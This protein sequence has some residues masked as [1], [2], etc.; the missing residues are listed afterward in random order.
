LEHQALGE[1]HRQALERYQ[2]ALEAL[3]FD[4]AL[5]GPATRDARARLLACQP[6][7]SPFRLVDQLSRPLPPP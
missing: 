3:P 6:S 5:H 7:S 1:P 4:V 2:Q